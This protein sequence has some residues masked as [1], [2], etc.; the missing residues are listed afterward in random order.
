M[1]F[2]ELFHIN[3]IC[4]CTMLGVLHWFV[5]TGSEERSLRKTQSASHERAF[6]ERAMDMSPRDYSLKY[7]WLM[8]S[9]DP[10]L[11]AYRNDEK[12]IRA[13]LGMDTR[14]NDIFQWLCPLVWV[15]TEKIVGVEGEKCKRI[16]TIGGKHCH[17]FTVVW[18]LSPLPQRRKYQGTIPP[19]MCGITTGTHRHVPERNPS[20]GV[21]AR[22]LPHIGSSSCPSF[23]NT[24]T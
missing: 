3:L 23:A 9:L 13:E 7:S 4:F 12:C 16:W 18:F 14:G 2:I 5:Q 15:F 24:R 21:P 22:Y 10:E 1:L 8:S 17:L 20:A 6:E 19:S 11:L